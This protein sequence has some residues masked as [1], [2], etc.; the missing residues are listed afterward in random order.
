MRAS[1][2]AIQLQRQAIRRPKPG[3]QSGRMKGLLLDRDPR[4][5]T[6]M[7]EQAPARDRRCPGRRKHPPTIRQVTNPDTGEELHL[8]EAPDGTHSEH[9]TRDEAQDAYDTWEA[10]Q[11]Y[12]D[13]ICER[14]SKTRKKAKDMDQAGD[15]MIGDKIVERL[16]RKSNRFGD[17]ASARKQALKLILEGFGDKIEI[18]SATL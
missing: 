3:N 12:Q 14:L 15:L 9:L 16:M 18:I 10:E 11:E 17:D 5:T 4:Q 8:F 2:R 7:L 6:P 1:S 13:W